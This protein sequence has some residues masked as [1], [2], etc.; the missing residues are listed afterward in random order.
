M[1]DNVLL[2]FWYYSECKKKLH[3]HL[4]K[5]KKKHNCGKRSMFDLSSHIYSQILDT[6]F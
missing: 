6:S 3:C 2:I 5:K 1:S 4:I